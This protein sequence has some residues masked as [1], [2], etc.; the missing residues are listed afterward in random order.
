MKNISNV[1][2]SKK[3]AE[4]GARNYNK[5]WYRC[6]NEESI[7]RNLLRVNNK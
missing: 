5:N 7:K 4:R 1:Y 3:D 2:V 6:V